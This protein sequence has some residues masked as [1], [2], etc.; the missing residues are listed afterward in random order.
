MKKSP[1]E[2][3]HLQKAF[4]PTFLV[5]FNKNPS[6]DII[7]YL[8]NSAGLSIEFRP[9]SQAEIVESSSF[10]W[11]RDP[12]TQKPA[13]YFGISKFLPVNDS[14]K[15]VVTYM[16]ASSLDGIEETLLLT[17]SECS[18]KVSEVIDSIVY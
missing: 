2:E 16:Y 1:G 15:T 17:K 14:T 18:W 4:S 9:A 3:S 12:Q 7:N 8:N 11:V 6:P 13:R 5:I 10:S